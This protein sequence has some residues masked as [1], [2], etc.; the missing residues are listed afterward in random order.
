VDARGNQLAPLLAEPPSSARGYHEEN[1]VLTPKNARGDHYV[2]DPS[3]GNRK[4]FDASGKPITEQQHREGTTAKPG[5]G[6]QGLPTEEQQSGRTAD[7][8]RELHEDLKRRY[9]R[10]SE[11]EVKLSEVLLNARATTVDGQQK[12]NNIQQKIV[13]AINSPA[14][15]LDTAAGEQAFLK[16]CR[17]CQA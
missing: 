2:D 4:Y 17:S 1:G 16:S 5:A 8:V 14:M 6:G 10:I 9:S 13:E 15:S 11:A 3:T 12:L 7:A